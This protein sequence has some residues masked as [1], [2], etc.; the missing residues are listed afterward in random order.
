[1]GREERDVM[2]GVIDRLPATILDWSSG[3]VTLDPVN[4]I[5]VRRPVTS[6]S[7]SGGGRWWSAQGGPP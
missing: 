3:L 5:E 4:I 1:M 7:S 6:L 2:M